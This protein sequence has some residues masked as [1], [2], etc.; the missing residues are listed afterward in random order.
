MH[1]QQNVQRVY[2]KTHEKDV[3]QDVETRPGIVIDNIFPPLL[4]LF[5][6]RLILGSLVLPPSSGLG[7]GIEGRRIASSFEVPRRI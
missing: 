1:S 5:Q 6:H 2:S 7:E 3:P 4:G